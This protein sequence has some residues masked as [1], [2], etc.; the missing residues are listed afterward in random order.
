MHIQ[1]QMLY[2]YMQSKTNY[3]TSISLG[4]DLRDP[5]GDD[6]VDTFKGDGDLLE[7][8]DFSFFSGD[9]SG[10]WEEESGETKAVSGECD[11]ESGDDP[12]R[13]DDSGS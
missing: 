13:I 5:S 11:E 10:E 3:P 12:E 7:Q 1:K 4:L 8:S 2:G 6:R 9:E